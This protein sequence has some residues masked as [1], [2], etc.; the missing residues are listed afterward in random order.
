MLTVVAMAIDPFAQQVVQY[1][2]CSTIAENEVAT[3]PFSNNYTDGYTSW[4]SSGSGMVDP[5]MQAAMYIGLLNPP[6]NISAAITTHSCRTGNCT[7][8]ATD[9]GATFLSLVYQSQCIDISD[10]IIYTFNTSRPP[11]ST[12]YFSNASL[13]GSTASLDFLTNNSGFS[14]HSEYVMKSSYQFPNSATRYPSSFLSRISFLMFMTSDVVSRMPVRAF[15]CEFYPTVTTF[16]A[17]IT[18]GRLV[19]HV[20]S[21]QRM[22]V[23]DVVGDTHSMLL[24]NKTVKDGVWHDCQG[25][26]DPSD[27][28]NTPVISYSQPGPPPFIGST[29]PTE[30]LTNK[31]VDGP[32]YWKRTTWWPQK[33]AYWLPDQSIAGL[34]RAMYLLLG[35]ESVGTITDL[36]GAFTGNLWSVNLWNNGTASLGT[37]QKA[38]DGL[39]SAISAQWRTGDGFSSNI[40]PAIGTV[41]QNETCIRVNW[42]WLALPAAFL[43]LT[44]VFFI[45][46]VVQTRSMNVWKS[47]MLAMLFNGL[48]VKTRDTFGSVVSLQDMKVAAGTAIVQLED[49]ADGFRFVG[50]RRLVRRFSSTSVTPS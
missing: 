40:G 24:I 46:T 50:K 10:R 28:N 4:R 21:S 9:D 2:S 15:E 23:Y 11:D 48:D 12:Y 20:L 27:D 45:L 3:I 30:V 5:Q 39:C 34:S 1:Y 19:E 36:T 6:T 18:N 8:A 31:S 29:L 26:P 49:T 41:H 37:V 14:V 35:N 44:V 7:F 16:G 32:G 22:D 13:P 17:N 38:M 33:C 25:L 43:F 47:S 42:A